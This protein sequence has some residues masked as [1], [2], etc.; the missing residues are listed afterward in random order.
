MIFGE[1]KDVYFY[2]IIKK[3]DEEYFQ[4]YRMYQ[5]NGTDKNEK[6]N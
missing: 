6:C 3:N 1:R 2:M 5:I 4:I